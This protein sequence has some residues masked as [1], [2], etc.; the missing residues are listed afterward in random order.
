MFHFYPTES[1]IPDC[2]TESL[3]IDYCG[4]WSI[5]MPLV[6]EY[7]VSLS[8]ARDSKWSA[9]THLNECLVFNKNPQRALAECLLEVLNKG[10]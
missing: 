10:E 6:V 5:L 9:A 2:P 8:A 4:D 1:W 7:R 3:I